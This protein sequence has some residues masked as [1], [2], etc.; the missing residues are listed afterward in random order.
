MDTDLK[1][2]L[3]PARQGVLWVRLGIA[4]FWRQPIAMAGM[5]F[6]FLGLMTLASMLPWVGGVLALMLFPSGSLGLMAATQEAT[7]GR[8]P[9]P[10]W[11]MAGW[12]GGAVLRQ[13][14]LILGALYAL[15]FVL[16]LLLSALA[17]S[18]EFARLYLLGGRLDN[19]VMEQPGFQA[20]IW[21]AMLFY[22]P[23]S[24]LFWHA[25]ALVFWHGVP[26][27]KSLFF[28]ITAC[29]TNWKAMLVYMVCWSAL[30][31]TTGLALMIAASL[32]GDSSAVGAALVPIML[33]LTAMF[34]GSA[35]FTYRDSF[36]LGS[37][38]H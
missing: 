25:P 17:D 14:M 4:T 22:L 12:T 19:E 6:M 20:A 36:A 10:K 7:Q 38:P 16:V 21:L 33:M 32:M 8:F 35:Y 37:D 24:A 26:A 29:L 27:F 18:G 11:L 9:K 1:L 2:Q 34:F 31:A 3:T 13:Q 23:L 30:Y 15:G 5:F 28:S